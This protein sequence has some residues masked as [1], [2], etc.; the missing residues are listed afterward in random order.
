MK[1]LRFLMM[2]WARR[3]GS[4]ASCFTGVHPYKLL[5]CMCAK[6]LQYCQILCDP[7]DCRSLWTVRLLCSW[8]PPRQEYCSGLLCLP[9]GNLLNTRIEPTSPV[10]PA[11][12]VGSLPLSHLRN[13]F[14]A[15]AVTVYFC[16]VLLPFEYV[17]YFFTFSLLHNRGWLEGVRVGRIPY[18]ELR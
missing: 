14:L 17:F 1:S 16:D 8:D 5:L 15:V 7:M 18:L 13:A 10:A 12:Q 11:L 6:S 4:R 9:P 2:F 3:S